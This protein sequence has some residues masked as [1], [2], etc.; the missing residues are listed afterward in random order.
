MY[1]VP[2]MTVN[3]GDTTAI[4]QLSLGSCLDNP[5]LAS[6]PEVQPRHL[7]TGIN[8]PPITV[9]GN[10]TISLRRDLPDLPIASPGLL[11]TNPL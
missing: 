9:N 2:M 4:S 7:M 3:D 8:K 6:C 10:G 11:A 1:N 5:A